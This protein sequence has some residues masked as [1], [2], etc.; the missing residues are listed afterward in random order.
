MNR[1][2]RTGF[3]AFATATILTLGGC[4]EPSKVKDEC[5]QS[6]TKAF[7][8][9][10][11][12]LKKVN[13]EPKWFKD[14]KFGI[15]T[16]WGPASQAFIN[17]APKEYMGGWHGMLMY[18]KEGIPNWKTGKIATGKDGI[19]KPTS[20]YLHHTEQFG[21][22]VANPEK[23]GYKSLIKSFK[24]TGFDAKEWADLFE[25]S[26]AKF[27]GPVA[28]H[29]D[30]F[31]MWNS[32]ATRW[33]SMN[34]GGKDISG[35]LKKE[36]EARG[37][38][39]IGSFHHAFTWKYF[40]PA[41]VYGGDQ[42]KEEDYDLYTEPH[43]YDSQMPTDRFHEEWWAKLKEY[44]DVYQPDVIWFDWWL[45]NMK[46]EYRQKFMAYYYNKANEWGK[47]VAICFKESTFPDETAIRDYERG[48]PNQTKPDYW[49]TDTSPGTWFY[50][51]NAKFV[52]ANEL[53]DIL[54]DIVAKNGNMLLN[55]PPD[56]DGTI[57]Q[58]M[59]DLLL[60]MGAWLK[61]NGDAIYGTRPWAC[62]G[63]GPTR[64][65][66][67]GHKIERKKIRYTEKDI[68]FTK[69]SDTEFFAIVMDTPKKDIVI[70]TLSTDIAVLPVAIEKV[71]LVGSQEEIKWKRTSKGLEIKAPSKYPT[72]YGHAFRI[73][74]EGYKE[75]NIGGDLEQDL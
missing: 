69:K 48:R 30:N 24:T 28:M 43:G 45:E 25:K 13:D 53:V 10:W 57:P 23:Y 3:Y 26:G 40:A 34:Y 39:F 37:M 61:V 16:H 15:Y 11:E 75:A 41:H 64:L 54:V 67:G 21:D 27:A 65:P 38:K 66:S 35:E 70:K 44:I 71:E 22:P 7:T 74:C 60:E 1:K 8:E 73:I 46:E 50:R 32:K 19:P 58:V 6:K 49:L 55:V 18:G 29:H 63:E 31:A 9:D 68:R 51:S 52:D 5:C 2:L 42:I 36:I 33:N 47:E 20:N 4:S 17:M 72:D 56:P 12:S 62:F 14:A 59:K